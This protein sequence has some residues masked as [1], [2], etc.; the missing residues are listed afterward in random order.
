MGEGESRA[1]SDLV[2]DGGEGYVDPAEAAGGGEAAT[3]TRWYES[4]EYQRL[5]M[6]RDEYS[7]LSMV[8]GEA[9]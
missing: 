7:G 5:K 9:A 3:V 6:L 1:V 4:P 8:V 2:G